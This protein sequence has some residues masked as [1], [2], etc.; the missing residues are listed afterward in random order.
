M[1]SAPAALRAAAVRVAGRLH[2]R[3]Q[4]RLV[5]SLTAASA[6]GDARLVG[7]LLRR[8]SLDV[9]AG[10]GRLRGRRV[11]RRLPTVAILARSQFTDDARELAAGLD[12]ERVLLI[13]REALKAIARGWLPQDTGDLT[14]RLVAARDATPMRRYGAF[15]DRVWDT[16]DPHDDVRLALT[17]NTCYWA[18][19]EL[20][21]ALDARDVAFVALHKENLK[22]AG[23]A[24]AWQPVYR[25]DRG[26]FLGRAVLVQNEAEGRL[27]TQGDVAPAERIHVVG[28]ARLDGFHAHR[29][30]TAG[31]TPTGDL[32]FASML[33]GAILPRP[34]GYRGSAT[35]LGIPIPDTQ[36]RPEHLVEASLAIHRVAVTVARAL[37]ERRVVVKTKGLPHDRTWVPR[38]LRHVAGPSGLPSNLMMIHGGDAAGITR[39]AALVAGLN[40]TML[41]ESIAAGR[42][43]VVLALGEA[44]DQA[45][46]FVIDLAG[47][48]PIVREEEDAVRSI[49]ALVTEPPQ[50]PAELDDVT[51]QVLERWTANSDGGAS[52][53][54]VATLRQ[55]LDA[56]STQLSTTRPSTRDANRPE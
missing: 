50:V 7:R 25:N 39:A 47:A 10:T 42:P 8:A 53:R 22:S 26:P 1:S 12:A 11:R 9:S 2:E 48:A 37:P 19:I 45:R 51:R 52:Q 5:R 38:I 20:G 18:E 56:S 21:A 35:E 13:S 43:A 41:L 30:R 32:V 27:Q 29:R 55:L 40:T 3:R 24:A 23:H 4:R 46:D 44:A 33:P 16:F 17:A 28:M 14:Y 31:S 49:V 54:V 6:R 15:L 34:S 36:Q